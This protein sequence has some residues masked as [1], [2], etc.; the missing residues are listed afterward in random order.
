[1]AIVLKPFPFAGDGFTLE[2]LAPGDER[3]FG[4]CTDGLVA[5][6]LIATGDASDE[7]IDLVAVPDYVTPDSSVDD[8]DQTAEQVGRRKRK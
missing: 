7:D 4:S 2:S 5:E 6:G 3:D 1:M 8:Q